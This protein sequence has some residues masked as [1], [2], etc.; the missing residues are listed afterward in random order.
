MSR[1]QFYFP[2]LENKFSWSQ[3]SSGTLKLAQNRARNLWTS[4]CKIVGLLFVYLCNSS[5]MCASETGSFYLLLWMTARECP[6][7]HSRG[8]VLGKQQIGCFNLHLNSGISALDWELGRNDFS[9]YRLPAGREMI[10]SQNPSIQSFLC[11]FLIPTCKNFSGSAV[12]F[13]TG[14]LLRI[15]HGRDR[16][17]FAQ[18]KKTDFYFSPS[19]L[20]QTGTW[21]LPVA[22]EPELPAA[23]L[24]AKDGVSI[25]WKTTAS[26]SLL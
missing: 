17:S 15:Q 4:I 21:N 13:C 7:P 16:V 1:L 8:H 9:R 12:R 20:I 6:C 26:L 22:N 19:N 5:W 18:H 3:Q 25:F 11:T 23:W 10:V 24:M 14:S 2:F